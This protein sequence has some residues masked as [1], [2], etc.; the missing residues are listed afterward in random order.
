[1]I[2]GI[3][4]YFASFYT[5]SIVFRSAVITFV[6]VFSLSMPEKFDRK[7]VALFAIKWV[8]VFLVYHLIGALS[9]GFMISFKAAPYWF[10]Y[11]EYM[12]VCLVFLLYTVF[13][14]RYSLNQRW[15]DGTFI[16]ACVLCIIQLSFSLGHYVDI[17]VEGLTIPFLLLTYSCMIVCAI[18]QQKFSLR[19]FAA[20]PFGGF[21]LL[22]L[23]NII[24]VTS[25]GVI[26][27][28]DTFWEMSGIYSIII[29]VIL[30]A[31][32]LLS[33]MSIYM[34]CAERDEMLR[35]RAENQMNQAMIQQFDLAQNNLSDLRKIR[36]DLKNQYAYMSMLLK[37]G[38]LE[39]LEELLESFSPQALEPENY[40]AC[41]NRDISAILTMEMRKAQLQ[42]VKL[43]CMILVPM[44]LPFKNSDLCSLLVN[45]IDNAIEANVRFEIKDDITVQINL[46]QQYLYI[47]VTNTLP[48]G[49][50]TEKLL[51]L[52]ST[53]EHAEEHGFGT[54]IV[55]GI[56]KKYKGYAVFDVDKNSFIGA[57]LL[58]ILWEEEE[59]E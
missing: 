51:R 35:I 32:V 52:R 19:R 26:Q 48:E 46:Q 27:F 50:D 38:R 4:G 1:M 25:V 47:G 57:V 42:G 34:V 43:D 13:V 28:M 53:K 29:Y 5:D 3:I 9:H 16:L 11:A 21:L 39:E 30:L 36:H 33:H 10:I 44:K 24:A 37:M 7:G 41:D 15:I 56:A 12:K 45:L 23:V 8:G 20:F 14:C 31:I 59:K 49:V 22:L 55:E 58:D 17:K 18:I 40:V 2:E 6:L 54:K